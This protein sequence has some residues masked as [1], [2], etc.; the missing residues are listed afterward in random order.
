MSPP[1]VLIVTGIHP[2]D[3]GG[4]ATHVH[5]LVPALRRR[6]WRTAVYTLTEED[7]PVREPGL[8]RVPRA[9]PWPVRYAHGVDFVRRHAAQ[10]DV[11]YGAGMHPVALAGGRMARRPVVLRIVGDVAWERARRQGLTDADFEA[12]QAAAGTPRVRAMKA[13]RARTAAAADAVVVPTPYLAQIVQGWAPAVR[14]VV[15]PNG[16]ALPE[17]GPAP[18]ALS[19]ADLRV[20]YV[21]RLE[22]HKRVERLIEAV[23]R[24]ERVAL[25]VVGA[26]PS[27]PVLR[28]AAARLGARVRFTGSLD[29]NGVAT[30]L[31]HADVFATVAAYEGLPHTVLEALTAG[32]PV[33]ASAVGGTADALTDGVDGLLLPTASVA[34]IADGLRRIRDDRSLHA[35][36]AEGA[37]ATGERW[38]FDTT[39]DRIDALLR[40]VAGRP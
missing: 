4:P 3:V 19:D 38:R 16:V 10:A 9:W 2:P 36:L 37:A 30:E 39:A 24:L 31:A 32:V 13:L 22:P 35:R 7:Q 25:T 8:T 27:A 17:S 18:A 11:V 12:F 5:D 40:E 29:R 28:D 21:G 6:G 34:E 20:L 14:P 1:S 15:V 33:L 23:G 26:G